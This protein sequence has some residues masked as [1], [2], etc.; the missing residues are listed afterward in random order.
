M[1]KLPSVATWLLFLPFAG[2]V[3][4]ACNFTGL[5][6]ATPANLADLRTPTPY[7]WTLTASATG[8][9]TDPDTITDDLT[10]FVDGTSF[11]AQSPIPTITFSADGF[12]YYTFTFPGMTVTSLTRGEQI[13]LV[14]QSGV[15]DTYTVPFTALTYTSTQTSSSIA[16]SLSPTSSFSSTTTSPTATPASVSPGLPI[17]GIVAGAVVGAAVVAAILVLGCYLILKSRRH[18]TTTQEFIQRRSEG[19]PEEEGK[20]RIENDGVSRPGAAT[21]TSGNLSG[22]Y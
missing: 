17:G 19:L 15:P 18:Q 22:V 8:C 2:L 11:T 1:M 7:T 16:S 3:S 10:W 9:A 21:Q 4:G 5:N 20:Y 12:Y 13:T 6:P 14:D